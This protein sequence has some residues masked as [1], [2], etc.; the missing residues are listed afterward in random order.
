[1]PA[2][3]GLYAD[4]GLLRYGQ[5]ELFD[6]DMISMAGAQNLYG[7]TPRPLFRISDRKYWL[8]NGAV[9]SLFLT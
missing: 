1:M 8:L 7:N 2:G 3:N 5:L 9:C 4:N 6:R